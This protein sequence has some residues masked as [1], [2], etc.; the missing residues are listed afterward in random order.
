MFGVVK[1][2]LNNIY[3]VTFILCFD[4]YKK[5]GTMTKLYSL[6][7]VCSLILLYSCKTASKAYQKGDY[8]DAIELGVKKLQK[9]PY[10]YETKDLVQKAYNYTVQD[11]ENQIKILSSS[12]DDDRY[13][14]IFR[15]YLYLQDLY[16][17][18]H[19]SPNAAR[20]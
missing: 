7:I 17:T 9:D 19:S 16:Q 18:I 15:Q 1:I 11:R 4:S 20:G 12:R 10:D 2:R 3:H 6:A 8:T 5:T 14:K 13:E